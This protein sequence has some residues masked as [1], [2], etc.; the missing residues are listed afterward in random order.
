MA[1]SKVSERASGAG[2]KPKG[3]KPAPKTVA[4]KK[5]P[6]RGASEPGAGK[7]EIKLQ[8]VRKRGEE[9]SMNIDALLAR[10]G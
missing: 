6:V 3:K 9:L 5:H 4:P 1:L 10:L 8:Q 7:I 2:G